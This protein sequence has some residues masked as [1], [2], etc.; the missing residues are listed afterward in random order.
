MSDV[1]IRVGGLSKQYRI[2]G[3]QEG[4]RT[5]REAMTRQFFPC[6]FKFHKING[7]GTAALI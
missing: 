5:I 6:L 2:G 3:K 4:Y 7:F 1:A